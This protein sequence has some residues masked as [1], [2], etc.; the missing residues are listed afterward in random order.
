MTN[1]MVP[2]QSIKDV[3]AMSCW[4]SSVVRSSSAAPT[5]R[6]ASPTAFEASAFRR[7]LSSITEAS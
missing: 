6:P 4:L 7:W 5:A 1:T 3:E 2:Q